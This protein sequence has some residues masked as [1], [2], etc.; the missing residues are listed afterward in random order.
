MSAKLNEL[1]ELMNKIHGAHQASI[2]ELRQVE[3]RLKSMKLLSG[4]VVR[5]EKVSPAYELSFSPTTNV[6]EFKHSGDSGEIYTMAQIEPRHMSIVMELTDKLFDALIRY[7]KPFGD[8]CESRTIK[9]RAEDGED[10]GTES[11]DRQ[12]G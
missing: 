6:L 2:K 11:G 4:G 10:S 7:H 12:T 5:T 9:L 1:S 3:A 8:E